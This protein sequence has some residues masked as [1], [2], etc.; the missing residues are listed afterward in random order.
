MCVC[1]CVHPYFGTLLLYLPELSCK[2][3]RPYTTSSEV[4]VVD[5]AICKQTQY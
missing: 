5:G 1:V 2:I 4:I 3:K